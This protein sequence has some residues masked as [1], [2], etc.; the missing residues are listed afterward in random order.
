MNVF[1]VS[2]RN[3]FRYRRR[4]VITSAAI[5]VGV[6]L[7]ILFDGLLVGSETDSTRNLQ[8]YET[9]T[10]EVFPDGYFEDRAFLPF[11]SF[12]DRADRDAIEA[13]LGKYPLA[14]RVQLSCELHFTEEYFATAG[15]ANAR[16]TAVDPTRDGAVFRVSRTVTEGRWLKS[17]DEGIVIGS[18]LA[19]DIGAK[20]GYS[21]TVECKG[22]GGFYQTFDSEIVGIV[23]TDDPYVNRYAVYMDLS[24]ADA[25]LALEGGVTEYDAKTPSPGSTSRDV[26]SLRDDAR[27]R[28]AGLADNV[29]SWQ[30]VSADVLQLM[31][32]KSG[33]SK[34]F[35]AFIFVI[36]AVGISNTMLMAVMERRSEIGMLRALGYGKTMIRSLFLLEGFWIGLFGTTVGLVT[37]CVGNFFMTVWGMDFSFMLRNMDA[38]YRISGVLRSA[39][40]FP[41][42]ARIAIFSLAISSFVAWFPSGRIL[43]DE[44][45]AIL[46]K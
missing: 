36:A 32:T 3:A 33:G 9:G 11:T 24:Y 1:S 41:G 10:I 23:T 26:A 27:L 40:N 20:V 17:G 29:Y 44:V 28:E 21:V 19:E 38:G 39:W 45:A 4:S 31:K 18:W 2:L 37:G 35:L 8:D 13:A 30:E 7:T 5:A 43:R 12:L 46:R 6:M 25:L 15:S 22:R 16:I 34:L 42:I 14:P